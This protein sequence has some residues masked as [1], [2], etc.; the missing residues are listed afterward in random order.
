M[1]PLVN[2]HTHLE[3]SWAH[4]LLP[5]TSQPFHEWMMRFVRRNR[6]SRQTANH[7]ARLQKGIEQG[8]AQL[9]ACGTTHVGDI[10]NSGLSIEPL[11]ASGLAGVVYIE[12]LGLEAGIGEYMLARAREWLAKYRPVERNGLR[13]GLSVH[14]PYSTTA[15]TFQKVAQLCLAEEIPLCI[16]LAESPAERELFATNGGPLAELP[17]QLGGTVRPNVPPVSPVRY[18]ADLGVL[19]AQPLLVHMVQVS[20]ADLDLV[21]EAGA[22]IVHCPRSNVR[23]ETGRMPLEQMLA[24]GIPVGL[25]TD[26]LASSPSL[27]VREEVP[28]AVAVHQEQVAEVRL[29]EML[30]N[31]AVFGPYFHA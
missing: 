8:I 12:V 17:I 3:L 6:L 10:S 11:L 14:A 20:P 19:E 5:A 4:S 28:T 29:A 30:H 31:T 1:P 18:L 22:T 13:L 24:R 7:E 2:A 16:H 15:V 27:D 23:L 21:A 25:G 9:L 26:S